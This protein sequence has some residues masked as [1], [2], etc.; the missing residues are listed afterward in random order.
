MTHKQLVKITRK[1]IRDYLALGT[2]AVLMGL[3]ISVFLIDAHVVPG[4]ISTIAMGLYYISGGSIPVGMALWFMNIPLFL[5]GT[6][7]LGMGFAARTIFGFTVFSL[8]IDLFRGELPGL[9]FIRWNTSAT[10]LDLLHN[11]FF[12]LTVIGAILLGVGMGMVLKNRGSIGGMDVITAVLQ[13]RYGIKPGKSIIYLN[14]IVILA[15]TFI[16][17]IK[18]IAQ[19]R[20]PYSLAFYA[21]MLTFIISRI[22]DMMLDG[23]DYARSALI[24]SDKC[25][26]IKDAI[27]NDLNRGA[28]AIKGRGLY[29]NTDRD[30][31]MTVITRKELPA[32]QEK[33]EAIDPKAFVVISTVHEVVGE[34]FRRRT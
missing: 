12:F 18:G 11:D 24:I 13:R 25:D 17:D 6:R 30:I 22:V 21:F 5:W 4:G 9:H 19:G 33:I 3:S 2:G 7:S 15:A 32:L 1:N 27:L 28:T 14:V 26:L 10:I 20:P 34:G 23:F 31:I 8:S 29:H 16:I